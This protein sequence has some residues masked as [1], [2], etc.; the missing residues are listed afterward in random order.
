MSYPKSGRNIH[1]E[2]AR[3]IR[4]PMNSAAALSITVD[5]T[6]DWT[7]KTLRKL[8]VVPKAAAKDAGANGGSSKNWFG[9][10]NSMSLT[11]FANLCRAKPELFAEF[12]RFVAMDSEI[13]PEVEAALLR[14]LI[15]VSRK[16]SSD[17]VRDAEDER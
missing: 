13:N 7:A 12:R 4:A 17:I 2:S 14:L 6:N 3:K 9:A 5:Q 15:D 8:W 1:A 11:H 10:R 16:R